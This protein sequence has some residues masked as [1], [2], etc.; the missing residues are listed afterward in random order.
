MAVPGFLLG[1]LVAADFCLGSY[2]WILF[3]G[4]ITVTWY[5]SQ[6]NVMQCCRFFNE[7]YPHMSLNKC[8]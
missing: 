2:R 8:V 7:Y 3:G 4:Y 6:V 1:G 5:E